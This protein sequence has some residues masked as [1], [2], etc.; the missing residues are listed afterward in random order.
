MYLI[1][2]MY[3]A[4]YEYIYIAISYLAMSVQAT[5]MHGGTGVGG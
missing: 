3:V 4:T 1:Y 2:Y 5:T